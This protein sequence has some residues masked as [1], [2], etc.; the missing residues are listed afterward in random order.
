MKIVSRQVGLSGIASSAA[1]ID[2]LR[3]LR[4]ITILPIVTLFFSQEL[5]P[6]PQY[7]QSHVLVV[8][9]TA[10]TLINQVKLFYKNIKLSKQEKTRIDKNHQA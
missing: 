7:R 6:S 3:S 4:N 1:T 9:F 2:R 10:Q 5:P 8:S